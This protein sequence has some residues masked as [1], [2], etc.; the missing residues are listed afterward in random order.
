M[1]LTQLERIKL[2]ERKEKIVDLAKDSKLKKAIL[3]KKL[4]LV[5]VFSL[6]LFMAMIL[7]FVTPVAQADDDGSDDDESSDSDN[8]SVSDDIEDEFE[9][10]VEVEAHS[11]EV[12]ITSVQ[13]N[14]EVKNGIEI[15]VTTEGG[16]EIEFTYKEEVNG[17][18]Q[19]VKPEIEFR[20]L[21]EFEDRNW[22]G[23]YDSSDNVISEYDL[24]DT[25]YDSI[26]YF[27]DKTLDNE[28]QHVFSMQTTDGIFKVVLHVVGSFAKFESGILTPTEVKIDIIVTDYPF[29]Q[30]N[31]KLA[32]LTKVETEMETE[33]DDDTFDEEEDLAEDE[34]EIELKSGDISAYFSWANNA[35]VDGVERPVVV[36]N[37]TDEDGDPI[38]YF[39]YDNGESI[40]HDPKI[41]VPYIGAIV[42]NG[43]TM[44]ILPYLIALLVG[45]LVIVSAVIWR[46]RRNGTRRG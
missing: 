34:D 24:R 33:F 11:T 15:E 19:Q 32:L 26:E 23:G 35:T 22:N 12:G 41:G 39:A 6:L 25:E 7:S 13:R 2:D 29:V 20:D 30:E 38:L 44:A 4:R 9:R 1:M 31:T 3:E 17:V 28:T 27:T 14:G 10:S 43:G 40:V 5:K 45:S 37:T 18:E 36:T 42:P 21:I 16:I 46:R 8:D